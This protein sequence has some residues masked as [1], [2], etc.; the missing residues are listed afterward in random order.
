MKT[1]VLGLNPTFR[2]VTLGFSFKKNF[3]KQRFLI[4]FFVL[5]ASDKSKDAGIKTKAR[6]KEARHK[7]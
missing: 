6:S 7:K 1:P 3:I 4:V 5:L 2:N